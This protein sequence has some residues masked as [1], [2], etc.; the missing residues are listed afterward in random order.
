M[1]PKKT[2]TP[3][4]DAAI[5][6]LIAQGVAD[7]LAKHK[8]NINSRNG[9]DSHK[10]RSGERRIV[11]TTRECTYSD[12]LKFQTLN[13][14]DN[15]GVIGLTQWF[16]KMEF[17]FHISNCTVSCQIKFATFTLLG[18]ALTWWNSHVKTVGHDAAYGMPWKPLKKMMT[19]KMFPEESDEVEK[20]VGGLPDMIQGSVMPSKPKIMQDAI[21]FKNY[22]IDQKIRTFSERQ[23]ENKRKLDDNSRNNH[24]Q[25]QPNKRQNVARAYTVGPVHGHYKKD[26]LKLKNKNHGNQVGNGEAQARTYAMGNAGTNSDSNVVTELGSFDVIIGMN[27]LSKYHAVIVCDK[28]IVRIPF[29]NEI[30]IVHGCPV[31]LAHITTKKAENKSKEKRLKDTPIIQDFLEVI[32][33]D[34]PGIPPNRQVEFQIDL[35]PGVAPV[36]RAPWE[37]RSCL[38]RRRMDHSGCASITEN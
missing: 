6:K 8:A 18:S 22:L 25:Q 4:T 28:K 21:E 17:V 38:S 36:A 10:S 35:I 27:W 5:K 19:A 13:F 26:F 11:P 7:A 3:M 16:E 20:Y 32:P 37:L 34:L 33:E 15:E 2:T 23:A 14:K 31:F 29:E 12:F 30:L 1:S 24:P 9:D